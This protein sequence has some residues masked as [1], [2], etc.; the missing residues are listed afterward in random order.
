[1]VRT[2]AN[3]PGAVGYETLWHIDRQTAE[4][5]LSVKPL[6]IDGTSPRD[7]EALAA[8]G[9][10]LY[11]TFNITTWG[12]GPAHDPLADE[13]AA[14][15]ISRAPDI[16]DEFAIVPAQRLRANGWR[17]DGDELVGEPRRP[18]EP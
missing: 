1:M 12:P 13:L 15:L 17:F 6:F 10:P 11:R 9:Y 16:A 4:H 2:V 3:T 14:Y 5:D 7:D 18:T 8:G